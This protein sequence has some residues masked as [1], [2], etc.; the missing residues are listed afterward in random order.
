MC[1]DEQ[2]MPFKG[3]LNVKQYVKS[4]PHPWEIKMFAL[5]GKNGMLYDF[6]IYQGATTELNPLQKEVFGLAGAVM[7]HLTQLI[8]EKNVLLSFDNFFSNYTVLPK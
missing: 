4:K 2:M 7:C 3:R 6:L 8:T 5:C 1:I